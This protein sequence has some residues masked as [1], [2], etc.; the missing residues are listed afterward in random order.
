MSN[1]SAK[2]S[3]QQ[4]RFETFDKYQAEHFRL[5]CEQRQPQAALTL[6]LYPQS[7][8]ANLLK[9]RIQALPKRQRKVQLSTKEIP[10]ITNEVASRF[11]ESNDTNSDK[12]KALAKTGFNSIKMA[13]FPGCFNPLHIGH[14][15]TALGA[16][17]FENLNGII[18]MP[19][20]T[21]PQKPFSLSFDIRHEI[22]TSIINQSNIQFTDF[23]S[24][25]LRQDMETI[26]GG[27]PF[28]E[29]GFTSRRRL[30]DIMAFSLL[31]ELNP[32]IEWVYYV[33]GVDKVNSYYRRQNQALLLDLLS[34]R[35]IKV[36]YSDREEKTFI[37]PPHNS[38]NLWFNN[39]IERG[40]FVRNDR[41]PS[42]D[43]S[44]TQI[45]N[46]IA[47]CEYDTLKYLLHFRSLPTIFSSRYCSSL[48]KPYRI[49]DAFSLE[50]WHNQLSS[51]Y[52]SD[53][54]TYETALKE[55]DRQKKELAMA[56]ILAG[57]PAT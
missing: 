21:N 20:G 33:T 43:V 24:S 57:S 41:F 25:T 55:S 50:Y 19:S 10:N 17:L 38:A 40:F 32:H 7:A 2:H 22:I 23:Y 12:T 34:P 9:A 15:S 35:D 54:Q 45:R 28:A 14:L 30:L 47:R 44:S 39:L 31:M 1:I 11:W 13:L 52:D 4:R 37:S 16:I 48:H 49:A 18:L 46:A 5:L 8:A 56:G 53:S 36:L 27:I 26:L 6:S 29:N 51:M 3:I 42:F